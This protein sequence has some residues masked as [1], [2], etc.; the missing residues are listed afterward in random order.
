MYFLVKLYPDNKPIPER[1]THDLFT[2]RPLLP[3]DYKLDYEA[4]MDSLDY[5]RE[6]NPSE[7]SASNFDLSQ[8]KKELENHL[9]DHLSKKSFTLTIASNEAEEIL[10]CIYINHLSGLLTWLKQ[11]REKISQVCDFEAQVYLWTRPSCIETDL[12]RK[13][14]EVLEKWL[15]EKWAFKSIC[16]QTY[17]ADVR[18]VANLLSIGLSQELSAALPKGNGKVGIYRRIK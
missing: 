6:F 1:V 15:E 11:S 13:I 3:A 7:W 18:Q 12:D 14:L 16:F 17:E 2:I 9:E 8:N 10:G 4:V 5:Y